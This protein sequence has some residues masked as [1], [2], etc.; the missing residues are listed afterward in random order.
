MAPWI[1]SLMVYYMQDFISIYSFWFFLFCCVF[2]FF[3]YNLKVSLTAHINLS[4]VWESPSRFLLI[5][6]VTNVTRSFSLPLGICF[7]DALLMAPQDQKAATFQMHPFWRVTSEVNWLALGPPRT[8]HC[9][10]LKENIKILGIVWYWIKCIL[11]VCCA[12]QFELPFCCYIASDSSHFL[13]FSKVFSTALIQ[14]KY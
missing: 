12:T 2:C 1:S 6:S 8:G 4:L 13:D 11:W 10:A 9:L 7:A 3:A 5:N 14:I